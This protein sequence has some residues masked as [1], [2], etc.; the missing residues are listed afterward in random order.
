VNVIAF[1]EVGMLSSLQ[2]NEGGKPFFAASVT[3]LFLMLSLPQLLL[4]YRKAESPL[5][6]MTR[7]DETTIC[8]PPAH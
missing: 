4:T 6:P 1:D 8:F 5:L 3:F 7:E 2:F